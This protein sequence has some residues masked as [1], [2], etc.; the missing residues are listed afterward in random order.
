MPIVESVN[1]EARMTEQPPFLPIK[2]I[3]LM[4]FRSIRGADIPLSNPLF[5]VGRN[6]AGKSNLL[7]ALAFISECM[8]QPLASVF[9]RQGGLDTIRY[10]SGTRR[11][12]GDFAIRVDFNFQGNPPAEGFYAFEIRAKAGHTFAVHEEQCVVHSDGKRHDFH[13]QGTRLLKCPSSLAPDVDPQALVLPLIGGSQPFSPVTRGLGS[14]Q[15]FSIQP[16]VIQ[17]LQEPDG[18]SLRLKSEGSNLVSVL[19]ELTRDPQA[20]TRLFDL[21]KS[22]VPGT[23]SVRPIRHGKM[24]SL[25]FRQKW[26]EAAG[27]RTVAHEAFSMSDGTLRALGILLAFLQKNRPILIGLEEPEAAIHPGALSCLLDL[28]RS[29]SRDT[30][31]IVS[32]HSPEL[33]D[34]KW[35]EPSHLRVVTWDAGATHVRP[36][37]PASVAAIQEHLM[38][39]GEL[40]RSNALE[41]IPDF[42]SERE[43]EQLNLFDDTV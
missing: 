2:R 24:L 22:V 37:G 6:G 13:R 9:E 34:A 39:A 11:R 19:K 28:I 5:L 7:T 17:S 10:R 20:Q 4:R 42:F 15:V 18:G 30:Q 1:P 25:E 14:M 36:L 12:P 8:S 3:R 43:A 27:A 33:L 41:P 26:N 38:G 40:L 16:S 29:F 32:T 23:E 35:I 31:I 21:L